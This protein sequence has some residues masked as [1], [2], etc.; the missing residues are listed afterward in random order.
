[1][2][3]TKLKRGSKLV[4][5]PCGREVVVDDW[6]AS[7]KT[8][9]CCGEPMKNSSRSKSKS[10]KAA[11]MKAKD[12]MTKDI[13]W[14][15]PQTSLR[16]AADKMK[17]N[18]TGALPICDGEKLTGMITDRDIVIRSIAQGKDPNNTPVSE[19]MSPEVDYC[20]EDEKIS[21]IAHMMENKKIRRLP[22]VNQDK[23]LVGMISLGDLATRG[24]SNFA[25]EILEKVSIHNK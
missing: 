2:A 18:D 5:V 23:K 12:V 24:E 19:A 16:E 13:V 9:W 4:C 8:I 7:E 17:A 6:G 20:L 15:T 22:V 11:T 1:M 10:K 25:C 14:I 21:K 3:K